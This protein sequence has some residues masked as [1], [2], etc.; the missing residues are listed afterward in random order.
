MH[1]KL[2]KKMEIPAGQKAADD[3]E[4]NKMEKVESAYYNPDLVPG[5]ESVAGIV[6]EFAPFVEAHKNM[7]KRPQTVSYRMLWRY[8]EYCKGLMPAF[9]DKALAKDEEAKEKLMDF[10]QEFGKYELEMERWYDHYMAFTALR[11][12][13]F[14]RF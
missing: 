6:D 12:S 7:P 13:I 9:I 2:G 3:P 11:R 4:D 14:N 8:L 5:F 1:G 10:I